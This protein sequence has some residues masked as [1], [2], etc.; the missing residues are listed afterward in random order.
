[1]PIK[2]L[3]ITNKPAYPSIDG[4]C[5]GMAKM[6]NFYDSSPDFS[7]DI[8]TLETFKH[9]FEKK[10]F[11]K[12]ISNDVSVFSVKINT[13][14]SAV[15]AIKALTTNKSYNLNRFKC[16]NFES[17]LAEILSQNKYDII[18]LENIFVAHYLDLIRE[19][20]KAKIILN[21]ANIEYEIWERMSVKSSWLKNRYFRIL[22]K[23]LKREEEEIWQKV[24]GI[25]CAT[26]KDKATISTVKTT[27][28]LITLPFYLDTSKYK[29]NETIIETPTF[30]HIGAMD[31]LPNVEGIEWFVEKVWR[32][33]TII[34][35]LHLAGKGMSEK[36][37]ELNSPKIA[38]H[39]FVKNAIDFMNAYD[40]MIVPLLSGSGIR[41]KI[42]EAMALGKCIISTTI[43]AEG[44]NYTVNKNILIANNEEEFFS[45]I[46]SLIT[47]PEKIKHIG[48]EARK[49]I[50][51]E[52]DI[53]LMGNLL[54][55]FL[56]KITQ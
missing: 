52:Y 7:L 55:S 29:V 47:H 2:I 16:V 26:D 51:E 49:L 21:S 48:N 40:I 46:N 18:Q 34:N 36:I 38:I 12:H 28:K 20:S 32:K 27:D 30:F 33:L 1:M 42:I 35:L 14:P 54:T 6:S 25:I 17:K 56:S 23:Q 41:V 4:G 11:E 45:I 39:G 8:F 24:D 3:Q 50:E 13:K 31:W 44:I 9:P 43:G 15:A 5:L 19:L 10:N 22:A 37:M 53:S